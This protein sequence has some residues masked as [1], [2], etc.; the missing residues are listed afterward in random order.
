MSFSLFKN[1]VWEAGVPELLTL[2]FTHSAQQLSWFSAASSWWLMVYST[3]KVPSGPERMFGLV[4][5]H[6]KQLN[7]AFKEEALEA[8]RRVRPRRR[9]FVRLFLC[10]SS[11]FF[12]SEQVNVWFQTWAAEFKVRHDRWKHDFMNW[13]TLK[14]RTFLLSCLLSD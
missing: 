6:Q 10:L 1:A 3:F 2:F 12:L 13:S 7:V 8:R 4:L 11:F 5:H 14:F 9:R